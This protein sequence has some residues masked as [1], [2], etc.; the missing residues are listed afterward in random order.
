MR[1]SCGKDELQDI[2]SRARDLDIK[3]LHLEVDRCNERARG[4]YLSL[5]FSSR[6]RFH[7]MSHVL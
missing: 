7:L 6:E 3:A 5:G 2:Q 4:P 1:E